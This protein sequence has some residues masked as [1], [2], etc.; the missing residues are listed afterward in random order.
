M[1]FIRNIVNYDLIVNDKPVSF[2]VKTMR[3]IENGKSAK[4]EGPHRHNFYTVIWAKN[5]AGEHKID[6]NT[7]RIEK[8]MLFFIHPEQVHHLHPENDPDGI[9]IVFTKDFLNRNGMEE[10]FIRGLNLF[11]SNGSTGFLKLTEEHPELN[12]LAEKME[13]TYRTSD[14]YKEARFGA[15]LKL[16]LILCQELTAQQIELPLTSEMPPE[17]VQK[18]KKMVDLNYLEWHKVNDYAEKLLISPN[19]LNEVIKKNTG[20]TAKEH[21]RNRL[22]DEAK[23]LSHFTHLSSKEIGFQLGFNDPSHFAKFLKKYVS[24]DSI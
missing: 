16:F 24:K 6:L 14:A 23:R 8:N 13:A 18:F 4:N 12:E 19:Y 2:A 21:I 11:H 10:K 20:R 9:V 22:I 1:A 15:Y 3:E 17:I 7:F 5:V